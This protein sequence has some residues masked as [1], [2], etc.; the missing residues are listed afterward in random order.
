LVLKRKSLKENFEVR[1][2]P[3]FFRGIYHNNPSVAFSPLL[4]YLSCLGNVV[5]KVT[6]ALI[7][8]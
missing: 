4:C 6:A 1:L 8:D 7:F 5:S 2:A 3:T